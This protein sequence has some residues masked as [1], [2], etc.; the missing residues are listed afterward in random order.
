MPSAMMMQPSLADWTITP[1]IRSSSRMVDF[2]SANM[3]EPPDGAPPVRQAFSLTDE[4]IVERH[5][6]PS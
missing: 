2:S 5:S 3:V 1:W 4:R 6:G